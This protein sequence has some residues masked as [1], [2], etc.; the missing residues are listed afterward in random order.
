MAVEVE[1]SS[2]REAAVEKALKK[3]VKMSSRNVIAIV[4]I[5]LLWDYLP[6][7][8]HRYQDLPCKIPLSG[9]FSGLGAVRFFDIMEVC[10][11]L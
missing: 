9:W 11:N 5:T 6:A 3:T 7:G 8:S 10:Q 1:W 4:V 2:A